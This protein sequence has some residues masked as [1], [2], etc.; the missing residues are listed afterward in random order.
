MY[1]H[2]PRGTKHDQLKQNKT[3]QKTDNKKCCT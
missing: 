2:T 1:W 3:H